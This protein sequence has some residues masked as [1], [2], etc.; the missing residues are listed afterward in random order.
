MRW[1]SR[2]AGCVAVALVC[3]VGCRGKTWRPP[4][5]MTAAPWFG[6]SALFSAA[7]TKRFAPLDVRVI[8]LST[9]FDAWR[10]TVEKRA[11]LFA[12]TVFDMTRAL[13]QGADLRIVMALDFSSGADGIIARE[14]IKDLQ[15][16][17]GKKVAVERCTTT[18]FVLLRALERVG[19]REDDVLLENIATDDALRALDNG[20]VDAAALWDPFLSR[21]QK[22]GRQILFTS[23]EIPGE[24]IDVLGVRADLLQDRRD[25]IDIIVRGVHAEVD[26]FA[27][28]RNYTIQTISLLNELTTDVAERSLGSVHFVTAAENVALFDRANPGAS[29]WR[30]Y[31][32]ASEFLIK[33]DML[34]HPVR[35]AADVIDAGSLARVVGLRP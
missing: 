20:L 18:H 4:I 1:F 10:A 22:P 27:A 26:R 30:T 28:D 17:K 32:K 2:V 8:T 11:D 14:G 3:G 23:A 35:P 21:A 12:G 31:E 19:M 33:H 6:N 25:D 24:V 16:L 7:E 29:I 13:D 9:D 15:G 34:R 5:R